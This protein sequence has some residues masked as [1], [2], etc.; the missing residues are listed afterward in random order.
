MGDA[1]MKSMVIH[2]T[3]TDPRT[4]S[5]IARC[6]G[7][8]AAN[9]FQVLAVG[10]G[11]EEVTVRKERLE[12][13]TLVEPR[14][15][16]FFLLSGL[17]L[18]LGITRMLKGKYATKREIDLWTSVALRFYRLYQFRLQWFGIP[19]QDRL[20]RSAFTRLLRRVPLLSLIVRLQSSSAVLGRNWAPYADR[21]AVIHVHD[22]WLMPA[23]LALA[24]RFGAKLIYDA[25]ELES[26]MN[27]STPAER[28]DIA[29]FEKVFW[30]SVDLLV[31]V[32]PAIRDYYLTI[33]G[34]KDT[35]VVHNSPLV[36]FLGQSKRPP[37]PSLKE[38]LGLT[39]AQK[40]GIY[41]GF[42]T[43]GRGL[44]NVSAILDGL[45]PDHFIALVGYGPLW[46]EAATGAI[47]PR[48]VTV[49]QI[50]HDEL[51]DEI[52]GVDYGL[53]LTEAVSRSDYLSLPNKLFELGFAGVPVIASD[54]P[55]QSRLVREYRLG[56]TVKPNPRS[57]VSAIAAVCEKPPVTRRADFFADFNPA[58]QMAPLV[59]IYDR[60]LGR[61]RP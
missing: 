57:V 8:L 35:V 32:S 44:G 14:R 27:G 3:H 56:V 4:D 13:Q 30:P 42:A 40:L 17:P 61:E 1:E 36:Q 23:G 22:V 31:T 50:K 54:L 46:E 5:R 6:I 39:S 24:R 9:G 2:L 52:F 28:R 25:H 55:E 58:S 26:D 7:H 60:Y 12:I 53:V 19:G 16:P 43:R 47:H 37:E 51:V 38:R 18:L 45:G 15:S 34:A 11:P 21:T 10:F 20:R 33:Y 48:L 41:L 49:P 59:K 29:K